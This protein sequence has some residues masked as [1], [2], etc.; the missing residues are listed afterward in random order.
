MNRKFVRRCISLITVF[1]ILLMLML[2]AAATVN[3][4]AISSATS[5]V[6]DE[7]I[8]LK[9]GQAWFVLK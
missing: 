7:P 3:E 2:Q 4:A 8:N 5:A 1:G 9:I 6:L